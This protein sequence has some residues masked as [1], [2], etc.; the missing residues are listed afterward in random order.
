[1]RARAD[2]LSEVVPGGLSVAIGQT[3]QASVRTGI[4]AWAIR[5]RAIARGA[6]QSPPVPM[7]DENAEALARGGAVLPRRP[8]LQWLENR[9]SIHRKKKFTRAALSTCGRPKINS[10]QL[11]AVLALQQQIHFRPT[12][13]AQVCGP[14][15]NSVRSELLVETTCHPPI[16]VGGGRLS[17]YRPSLA[18]FG[19]QPG[20]THGHGRGKGDASGALCF[21]C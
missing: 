6:A 1:M 4:T 17:I 5:G 18:G 13:S 15:C 19:R 16:R 11:L 10:H 21:C 2:A 9:P 20:R 3:R 8:R 7:E 12:Q 14:R